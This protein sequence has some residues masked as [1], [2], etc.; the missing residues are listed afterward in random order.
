[1]VYIV[2]E[3]GGGGATPIHTLRRAL[4]IRT[5]LSYLQHFLPQIWGRFLRAGEHCADCTVQWYRKETGSLLV[6]SGRERA[7]GP[8]VG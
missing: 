3:V 5:E 6:S 2:V 4:C 1:M 8:S 7:P